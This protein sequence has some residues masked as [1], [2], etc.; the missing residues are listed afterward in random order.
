MPY[1][2]ADGTVGGKPTLMGQVF[3]FLSG[4]R[5]C[6]LAVARF[7]VVPVTIKDVS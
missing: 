1:I 6:A 7:D 5:K 4:K 2:S 3:G